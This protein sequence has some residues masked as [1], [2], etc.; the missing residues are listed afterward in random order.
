M[1]QTNSES[2]TVT[3]VPE[4]LGKRTRTEEQEIRI[5]EYGKS[6]RVYIRNLLKA[7]YLLDIH[8]SNGESPRIIRLYDTWIPVCITDQVPTSML[9]NSLE[10][11]QGLT[12]GIF[13][14][15]SAEKAEAI[16]AGDE[17]K[18]E[19]ERIRKLTEVQ[20]L[21]EDDVTPVQ[22]M[23]DS[24]FKNVRSALKDVLA[25]TD[26][27][28]AERYRNLLSMHMSDGLSPHE[29]DFIMSSV[30]QG[31]DAYKWAEATKTMLQRQ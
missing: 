26:I 31:S 27:E 1:S 12:K 18:V 3:R 8:P 14:I 28:E 2:V 9:K 10:F 24:S 17:A 11:R 21:E 19:L 23:T 20:A 7:D 4:S 6:D 15:V 25:R 16:L 22:A 30:T 13:E 29:F 5:D